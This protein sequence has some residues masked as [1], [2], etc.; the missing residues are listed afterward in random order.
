MAFLKPQTT[1]LVEI[2]HNLF[3]IKNI[4]VWV[5]LD[6]KNHPEIQGNK[7]HKLRLNLAYLKQ[8]Q[9]TSILTFGG[10]Y[11]NH[12]AA[13]AAAGK[14]L[15]IE[16]IGVIRGDELKNQYDKWSPTLKLAH[17]NGMT[18]KFVSRSEYRLR[19]NQD[20]LTYLKTQY[21]NSYI[22]PEGGTNLY[23]IEGFKFLMD[24]IESQNPN[25]THLYTAVGTGGTLAGISYYSTPTVNQLSSPQISRNIIG[26]ST[27]KN[28]Q[29]LEK[30]IEQYINQI[31]EKE[32]G[33]VL[34]DS[35]VFNWRLL[36]DYH[37]G[38]YAQQTPE[39][40]AFINEFE[41]THEIPLD[42]VYTSKTFYA[43]FKELTIGKVPENSQVILY[44]S[45]GLQGNQKL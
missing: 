38:G 17:K 23:A 11:S 18:F 12:I 27:I 28:G 32:H 13:T 35:S 2:Y 19:H 24:D 8:Q 43:F 7:L 16:A 5:K 25:W 30:D 4:R 29:Y 1:P 3:N 40:K 6:Y 44:H 22:L 21:P 33:L 36:T 34:K 39:L 26:V 10:A 20:Y 37:H 41:S 9:K 42:S 45:G 31:Y 14:E 15:K